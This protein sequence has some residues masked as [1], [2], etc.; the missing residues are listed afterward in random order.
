MACATSANGSAD[1]KLSKSELKKL[2][3]ADGGRV[4]SLFGAAEC[5]YGK[6]F[7]VH[8]RLVGASGIG[9]RA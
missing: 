5:G 9:H 8:R 3:K 7:E 6:L 2:L 1:G 4:K